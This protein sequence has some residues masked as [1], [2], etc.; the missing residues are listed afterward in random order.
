[1]KVARACRSI[2]HLL[3]ADDSL[4]FC[5]AQKEECQT[6]LRILKEY[7]EVSSQ[8]INFDKS[9]IQFDHKIEESAR[10]ELR[11]I[12]GIQ[13]LGGM[14]SYLG[15][16]E[17]L[18]GSKIQVFSFVQDRLNTR[19]TGWAFRFFTKGGKEVIIKS[20]VTA[21]PNHVISCYHLPKATAKKIDEC[22]STILVESR[23]KHERHALEIVGQSFWGKIPRYHFP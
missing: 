1:M 17:N 20:V 4:F 18:G 19:V 22:G 21:L 23:G 8:L 15:L 13:N 6:I 7:E 9:S 12:L 10:Q 14:G 2:S 3:F 11:D 5:K 16:P